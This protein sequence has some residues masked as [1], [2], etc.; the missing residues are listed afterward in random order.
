MK[1]SFQIFT[2]KKYI[3][4]SRFAETIPLFQEFKMYIEN[5]KKLEYNINK[6]K[7]AIN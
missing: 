5:A 2:A 3:Y 4:I 1:E 7:K 6:K